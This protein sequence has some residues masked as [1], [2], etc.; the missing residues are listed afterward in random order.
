MAMHRQ[1]FIAAGGCSNA[2]PGSSI[3]KPVP[4][5]RLLKMGA[6]YS[7][8]KGIKGLP[9]VQ[10]LARKINP[11]RPDPSNGRC[12]IRDF[13][14][15]KRMA[16]RHGIS[17]KSRTVL[18]IGS[19]WFP[20]FSI[21]FALYGAEKVI[22]TD[23]TASMDDET[24]D[25]A[26][27]FLPQAAAI[28]VEEGEI[29]AEDA[30]HISS[31]VPNISTSKNRFEY[32]APF[33]PEKYTGSSDFII[34]R[35]VIEHIAEQELRPTMTAFR[36]LLLPGGYML[37]AIDNSDH[38][39]HGQMNISPVNFLTIPKGLWD[40]INS[41]SYP[42]NRL[43]HSNY[44]KLFS[45]CGCEVVEA[46]GRSHP[47]ALKDLISFEKRNAIDLAFVENSNLEDLAILDSYFLTR[48]C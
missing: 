44:K 15:L 22:L 7:V 9:G 18:E 45:E 32:I 13:F 47:R 25:E 42:Q 10:A 36:N 6:A 16:E 17:F 11:P 35:T 30:Q 5:L 24:F 34:S 39:S 41:I 31:A 4:Y 29:S 23:I 46:Q 28:L 14:I 21:L 27:A 3:N 38:L 33:D 1:H 48:R 12:A 26:V 40:L 43:R 8:K 20:I 19:G 37:H 2:K